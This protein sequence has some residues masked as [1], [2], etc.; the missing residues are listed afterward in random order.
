MISLQKPCKQEDSR[1]K[2]LVLKETKQ[3]KQKR[4][5]PGIRYTVKLSLKTEEEIETL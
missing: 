3:N 5:Q 1:L 2:D 4:Y